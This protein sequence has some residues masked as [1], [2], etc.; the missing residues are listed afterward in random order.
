[1][2]IGD[3]IISSLTLNRLVL[4]TFKEIMFQL[5]QE[6]VEAIEEQQHDVVS[7]TKCAMCGHEGRRRKGLKMRSRRRMLS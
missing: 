7:W 3:M 6:N 4:C 1:M 2:I 5:K